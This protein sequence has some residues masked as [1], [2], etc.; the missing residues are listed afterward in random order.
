[1]S[2]IRKN[3][4]SVSP[5]WSGA[6]TFWMGSDQYSLKNAL[7]MEPLE[8]PL[9]RITRVFQIE[10]KSLLTRREFVS[11]GIEYQSDFRECY[12]SLKS[13]PPEM[14]GI[15]RVRISNREAAHFLFK[16][17]WREPTALLMPFFLP[18]FVAILIGL[19]GAWDDYILHDREILSFFAR[20][21]CDVDCVAKVMR[22]HTLVGFLFLV[23]LGILLLPLG[24]L[25]FQAPRYRSALNFRMIQAYSVVTLTVGLFVFVQLVA[26]FPFR[27]YGKFVE[28][29][30]DPKVERVLS[31]LK[32]KK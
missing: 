19:L 1:M 25:F 11:Y 28:L 14:K 23:P 18:F 15:E 9:N 26:F 2:G 29:G 5:K 13:L 20:P 16:H 31:N 21:G 12:I 24:F 8:I 32:T 6:I 7:K 27:Q 4:I 3:S 17:S 10:S 30:F 22:I